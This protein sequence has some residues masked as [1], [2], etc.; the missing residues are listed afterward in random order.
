MNTA[1]NEDN[2]KLSGLPKNAPH[3]A[4]SVIKLEI[5]EPLNIDYGFVKSLDG[6]NILLTPE[7]ALLT[8]KPQFE[9]IPE[10]AYDGDEAYF[11]NWQTCIP[12][13]RKNT[14]TAAHWKIE[15]KEAGN[16]NVI[17]FLS[18][19]TPNNVVT[20]KS[21]KLIKTTLAKSF[22]LDVYKYVDLGKLSLKKGVNTLTFTGGKKNEVWDNIQLKHIKLVSTY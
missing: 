5:H 12:N 21:G 14:G 8:I 1:L 11:K 7:N 10:V 6:K 3:E 9:C 22:G 13:S 20:I 18:T 4:V 2:T 19:E 17:A 16:Y 15:V